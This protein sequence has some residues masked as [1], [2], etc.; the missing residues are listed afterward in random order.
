MAD[1]STASPQPR[2][3]VFD[4]T[5]DAVSDFAFDAKV[6]TV[7]DDMVD[8]SVP[9]YK[10]IQ[11]MTGELTADFAVAGTNVYVLGCSTG[12]TL[13]VVDKAVDTPVHLIG[14]DNSDEMLA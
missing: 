1:Q 6:A 12:T 11:R 14:V 4:E 8:R 10:E 7:F 2:D 3:K 5:L 9:F 13:L